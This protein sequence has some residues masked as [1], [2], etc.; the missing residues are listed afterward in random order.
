MMMMMMVVVVVVVVLVVLYVW[1]PVAFTNV[2][3]K[4]FSLSR[5]N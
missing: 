4:Y 5:H 2:N 1:H 3:K